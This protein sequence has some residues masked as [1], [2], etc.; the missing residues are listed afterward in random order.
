MIMNQDLLLQAILENPEDQTIRLIYADWLEERGNPR[1][2]FIRVQIQLRRMSQADPAYPE[3]RLRELNLIQQHKEEWFGGLR[4]SFYYW[5]CRAGFIDEVRGTAAAFLTHA[6][7]LFALHPVLQVILEVEDEILR[8]LGDC[9][10]F[11]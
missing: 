11:Y 3:L 9:A 6:D 10:Y 2:E 1:G 8:P 7:A 5:E 4:K